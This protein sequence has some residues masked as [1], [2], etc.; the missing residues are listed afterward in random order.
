MSGLDFT[1]KL[2]GR[3]AHHTVRPALLRYLRR[4]RTTRF[5]GLRL[6]VLPGVF[7]PS[8][9][10][11]TRTFAAFLGQQEL[12]GRSLLDIGCGSGALGLVAARAGAAVV[13]VDINADAVRCA[14]ANA[15]TNG[16]RLEVLRSDLLD[17]VA[18][19][20]FDIIVINPPYFPGAPRDDADRA[21]H[22]GEGMSYFGRLFGQLAARPGAADGVV[23]MILADNCDLTAIAGL[24][25]A[26]GLWMREI[27]SERAL[28]EMQRIFRVDVRQ[29]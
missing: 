7:H 3:A 26:A 15:E 17:A 27:H 4:P 29:R 11:S 14:A 23:W 2:L 19:R 22:A 12:K 16:L 28:W 10:F 20:T 6:K 13:A 24:A 9:Y 25:E 1:A 5:L 8:F 21:W 18:Q